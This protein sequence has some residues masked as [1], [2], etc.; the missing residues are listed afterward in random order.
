[1]QLPSPGHTPD[2]FRWASPGH[3][4]IGPTA[5]ERWVPDTIVSFQW[6]E[7]CILSFPACLAQSPARRF[8]LE[9]ALVGMAAEPPSMAALA[10]KFGSDSEEDEPT[11]THAHAEAP[12]AL[13]EA[14]AQQAP[15]LAPPQVRAAGA[16]G[17]LPHGAAGSNDEDDDEE[18][19]YD[20]YDEE[21]ELASALQWADLQDG[22]R[23]DATRGLGGNP[24]APPPTHPAASL[25]VPRTR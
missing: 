9:Q 7:S 15:G 12:P 2:T 5:L 23:R 25:L 16:E 10:S 24:S 6:R 1:M 4:C 13:E 11:V 14:G 18:E 20:S 17:S 8:P 3:A 19:D 22:E 21:E